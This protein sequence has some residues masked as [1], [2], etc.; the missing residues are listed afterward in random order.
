VTVAQMCE[1]VKAL[2]GEHDNPLEYVI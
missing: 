2:Q 1:R